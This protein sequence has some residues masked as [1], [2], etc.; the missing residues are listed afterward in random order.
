MQDVMESRLAPRPDHVP[1]DRVRDFDLYNIPG[2]GDDIQAA[3]SVIQQ[4]SPDIF[5]TPHNG[6]H[7]VATRAE[8][9]LVMQRDHSRFSYRNIVLPP[10]PEGTPRQIPLEIDP[11][12]HARYRRP[13]MQ[14]LLPSIVSELEE[15]VRQVA[16]DAAEKLKPL[17]ECEFVEDFAKVLPIHVFLELVQI[18][19][20]DK[21][22]LLT[23]AEDS[24]RGS[25]AEIRLGSQR[26]MG[27]YLLPWIQARREKP[28]DDLLCKLVNVDIN[29]ERIS[30]M[31]AISYATLVLFG[32][33]DTVA[34]MIAFFARF[35]AQNPM[36]RRQLVERLDDDAFVKNAIEELIRR[37][38]LANTARVITHDFDYN[39]TQFRAG[40]RILPA[41]LF[42][43]VDERVT[44]DPLE[45]DFSRQKP[46]HAAFG[47]GPHACPGAVL[48]RR[49]LRIFLEEWLRRI[50]E[51]RIKPG[52]QPVLATGMVNGVLRL[53]LVWP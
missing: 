13:L 36:H 42:V 34:G 39:G 32:G 31:E 53:D 11:P 6:G 35:L 7:W 15:N 44:A 17:G 30:E 29:G 9:I 48:A 4:S 1:A 50:P 21:A 24:V 33:L 16:I 25:T 26:A 20:D 12:E 5:W 3:Y 19:L 43:G 41:N 28:G 18:P 10:M 38:G 49:E 51:F 52:T 14:A 37:H 8:D 46:V 47:N 40:D 27:A 22:Y 2:A 23:L 45:V